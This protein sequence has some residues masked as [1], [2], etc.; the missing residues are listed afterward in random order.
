MNVKNLELPENSQHLDMQIGLEEMLHNKMRLKTCYSA[1][2]LQRAIQYSGPR[3]TFRS[4]IDNA[5]ER[6]QFKLIEYDGRRYYYRGIPI[7]RELHYV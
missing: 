1:S 6:K 3:M 4:V 2:H 5:V 7:I